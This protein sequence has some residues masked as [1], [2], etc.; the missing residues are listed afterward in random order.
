MFTI[1]RLDRET[2]GLLLLTN[3]GELAQQLTHPSFQVEKKYIAECEGIF[4][5]RARYA[6]LDGIMDDGELLRA[7]RVTKFREH[8]GTFLL[9]VVLTEG[10]KREVRRLCASL[11]IPVIRLA[12]IEFGGLQL[13]DLPTGAWRPLDEYELR[14]LSD[15]KFASRKK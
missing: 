10:K 12:R 13:G 1:G 8:D 3:D 4:T 6:M 15:A 7:K 9:E 2:E 11:G 5:D 14:L